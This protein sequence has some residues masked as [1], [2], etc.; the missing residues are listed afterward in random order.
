MHE[1]V[2]MLDLL[3]ASTSVVFAT[4][5]AICDWYVAAEPAPDR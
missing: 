5:G 3:Q 1:L 2:R 4:G